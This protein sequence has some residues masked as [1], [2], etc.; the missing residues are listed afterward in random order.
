[1]LPLRQRMGPVRET[2]RKVACHGHVTTKAVAA[3]EPK[4]VMTWPASQ[5]FH[6]TPHRELLK[7]AR[8]ALLECCGDGIGGLVAEVVVA[9]ITLGQGGHGR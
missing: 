9:E 4:M 8:G 5:S 7:L 1:M 3:E 2:A 6:V